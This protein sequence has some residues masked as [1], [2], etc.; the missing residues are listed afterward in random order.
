VRRRARLE[1]DVTYDAERAAQTI[2]TPES[3]LPVVRTMT[4]R[5]FR[6]SGYRFCDQNTRKLLIE[7]IF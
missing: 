3:V 1:T 2:A 4:R 7:S 6:K 5:V